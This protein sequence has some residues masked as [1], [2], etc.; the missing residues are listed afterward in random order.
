MAGSSCLPLLRRFL[1][2]GTR[3]CHLVDL[4]RAVD[5]R[6]RLV[7]GRLVR[8]GF[9]RRVLAA[10]GS[11]LIG[12]LLDRHGARLALCLAVLVTGITMM[13]LSPAQFIRAVHKQQ[14]R[15]NSDWVSDSSIIV[16]PVTRTARHN[17]RRAPWRSSSGPI[18]GDPNAAN[19]PPSETAPDKAGPRPAELAGQRLDKDR[20]G[21]NG[22]SL[23]R[24]TGAAE[25][26]KDDPAIKRTKGR[27]LSRRGNAPLLDG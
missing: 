1:A 13:L 24:E 23:T 22:G 18:S 27:A 2:S 6:V 9:A 21:G 14:I 11:P 10:L 26:G 20:Q 16:M 4:C 19:T 17:A 7:A 15:D 5:P 8:G 12:P 3:R 25:A